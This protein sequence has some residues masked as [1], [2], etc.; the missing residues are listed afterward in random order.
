[1]LDIFNSDA[2]S[3]VSLTVA[4]EKLPYVPSRV[5][6]MNL[7]APTP[8]TTSVAIVEEKRGK[9]TLLP[10]RPRDYQPSTANSEERRKLWTFP[11]P[12]VPNNSSI[13]ADDLQGKRAFGSE[14]AL[15]VYT[16]VV[17]ERMEK[18]KQDHEVT[19]E[20]HRVGALKGIVLD[21]D[22]TTEVVDFFDQFG[23]TQ[24]T[25]PVDFADAGTEDDADPAAN[26]K[27]V[28]TVLERQMQ[29]ALGATPFNGIH[30]FCGDNFFDS[31]V[32]HATVKRAY[33][34]WQE[35]AHLR[36]L[37]LGPSGF[38]FV[39]G[40]TFENYRGKIGNIDFFDPDE[41]IAVPLGTR[42]IF[43]EAIAPAPFVETVNTRGKKIY[44]KQERM[45]FDRGI[46]LYTESNVLYMCTRPRC[47]IKL[48]GYNT[49]DNSDFVS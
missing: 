44:V 47:L 4:M 11:V 30:V 49:V 42:D 5:G 2:F 6:Q 7:F 41:A 27:Q 38:Q 37:Q 16:T 28:C 29:L 14:D 24:L 35:G 13:W 25:I 17:N 8:Q 18:M 9:L 36:T 23:I 3:L 15:E 43:I 20:W 40:I 21:A 32:S 22:G 12:H 34:R 48:Q 33:E 10:T 39:P 31:F 26:M 46:E 1:V 45:K 19:H